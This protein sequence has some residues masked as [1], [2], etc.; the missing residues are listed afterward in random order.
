MCRLHSLVACAVVFSLTGRAIAQTGTTQPAAPNIQTP[1]TAVLPGTPPSAFAVIEGR[2]L[3]A[4]SAPLPGATVRLRDART[5]R[6][7]AVATANEAGA[8]SFRTVDPGSYII[9][10]LGGDAT[11]RA[12][13]QLVSVNAGETALMDVKLPSRLEAFAGFLGHSAPQAAAIAAA[14]AAAGVLAVQSTT[15][16]SPR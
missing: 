2:A 16:V 15:D 9:E 12:T 7:V 14:A 5:G 4:T 6:A 13:S 10:L 11:I 8:F 3:T 1:A